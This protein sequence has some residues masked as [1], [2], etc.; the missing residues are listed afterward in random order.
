[1]PLFLPSAIPEGRL[2]AGG[3]TYYSVP[4]VDAVAVSSVVLTANNDRY[5]P[6]IV[7][8]PITLDRLA[9]EVTAA[10]AGGTTIRLAI[11]TAGPDWQPTALVIDAGTV[12]ADANAIVTA[13]I[14]QALAAGRYLFAL[15]SDAGPTLRTIQGGSRMPGYQLGANAIINRMTVAR[16][17]GAF[18]S[19][20]TAV[21]APGASTTPMQHAIFCRVSAP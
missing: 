1:M 8:T 15:N 20:G 13:T 12:A 3:T 5:E 2:V 6:I 11:F 14:N 16:T 19:P 18:S 4:G 9:V 7:V 17:Y 10:S 21:A